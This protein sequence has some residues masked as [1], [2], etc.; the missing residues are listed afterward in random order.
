MK[1]FLLI[2]S[3]ATAASINSNQKPFGSDTMSKVTEPFET[4]GDVNPKVIDEWIVTIMEKWPNATNDNL[5]LTLKD[6]YNSGIDFALTPQQITKNLNLG[7][8]TDNEFDEWLQMIQ[9]MTRENNTKLKTLTGGDEYTSAR[10]AMTNPMYEKLFKGKNSIEIPLNV[11]PTIANAVKMVVNEQGC[12][13]AM[14]ILGNQGYLDFGNNDGLKIT[15]DRRKWMRAFC[16]SYQIVRSLD[17]GDPIAHCFV[18]CIFQQIQWFIWVLAPT[19][20]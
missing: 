13:F 5:L 17:S 9:S 1:F 11:N 14:K 6:Y 8:F 16:R 7:S 15:H 12:D 3:L 19:S 18:Y 4:N 20:F 2:V 10:V